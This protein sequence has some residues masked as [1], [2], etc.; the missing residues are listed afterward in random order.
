MGIRF[1]G[2]KNGEC[3]RNH[4][5]KKNDSR[6]FHISLT[7]LM[8]NKFQY[9]SHAIKSYLIIKIATTFIAFDILS[10]HPVLIEFDV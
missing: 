9:C 4:E 1:L 8:D 2:V 10:L 5:K 3:G 7:A 6:K